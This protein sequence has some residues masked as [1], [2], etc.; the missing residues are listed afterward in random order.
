MKVDS[1]TYE[2][3]LVRGA[4]VNVTGPDLQSCPAVKTNVGSEGRQER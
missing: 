3:A 4:R 2:M 1:N